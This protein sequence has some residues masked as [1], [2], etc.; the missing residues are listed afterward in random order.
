MTKLY[1]AYGSNM[2]IRHLTERTNS[3]RMVGIGYLPDKQVVFNKRSK[4]DGSGK[5]NIIDNQANRAWGVL[6]E[7]DD[8]DLQILDRIEGG[9]DREVLQAIT[10]KGDNVEVV[11]YISGQ[12]I[13]PP[14]AY[15]WY[16]EI[17]VHGAKENGLPGD[18]ITYLKSLP[19]VP[20]L[21]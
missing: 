20:N 4:K 21:D 7:I 16:K 1:F 3:A 12:L 5:A 8:A 15:D 19:S 6:F 14:V 13:D 11:T 18:Y 10:D 2:N 17:I 9:Y